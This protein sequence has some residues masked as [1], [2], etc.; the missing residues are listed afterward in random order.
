[1]LNFIECVFQK[2]GVKYTQSWLKKQIETIPNITSIYGLCHVMSLYKLYYQCVKVVH[3]ENLTLIKTPCII[4]YKNQFMIVESVTDSL[5]KL[6]DGTRNKTITVSSKIFV[7]DWNGV[8]ILISVSDNSSEPEYKT[9]LINESI[10]VL[11]KTGIGL[12]IV[13]ICIIGVLQNH[14][15]QYIYWWILIFINMLGL[16]VSYLLLLQQLHIP[17]NVSKTVCDLVKKGSCESVSQSNAANFFKVAKF[18]EIGFGYFFVNAFVLIWIPQLLNS[19]FWIATCTLPFTLWSVWYQK[20]RIKS[21][22]ILC[23]SSIV[24]LWA[25][26]IVCFVSRELYDYSFILNNTIYL[27]SGYVLAVLLLSELMYIL[28]KHQ[29]S[30]QLLK[31]FN[32]LKE[33]GMV[34]TAIEGN[35]ERFDTSDDNCSSLVFGNPDALHQITV[36]SNPFCNPCSAMHARLNDFPGVNVSVKYVFTYFSPEYDFA[37][38]YIIA[39]YQQLG[40]SQTWD[41]LTE[42]YEKGRQY[43]K[44]FFNKYNLD[45]TTENVLKEVEKH[46][47]WHSDNR[48]QGTPTVLINGIELV[49]PYSL[50]DYYYFPI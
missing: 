9:H 7:Q 38:R 49:P 11:K 2:L 3:K 10:Q 33:N 34:F 37:N 29:Q 12:C 46:R 21:W 45:I 28:S 15:V 22:C 50:E 39:A 27:I 32:I 43:G 47:A 16:G 17:N 14:M 8:M 26:V 20:F 1:M 25:Q 6:K 36:F 13:A 42:W 18:S 4:I 23:L 44:S 30:K 35:A 31:D 19:Y 40:A 5:I 48:L 41:I 24:L